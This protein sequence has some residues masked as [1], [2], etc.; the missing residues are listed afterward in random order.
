MW[1]NSETFSVLNSIKTRDWGDLLGWLGAL[2]SKG[3]NYW[4]HGLW[5]HMS[6]TNR[7]CAC[8]GGSKILS[9]LIRFF[10]E[11]NS[12][13]GWVLVGFGGLDFWD[14][15]CLK[16]LLLFQGTPPRIP[17]HQPTQINNNS[18]LVD[19]WTAGDFPTKFSQDLIGKSVTWKP[20]YIIASLFWPT[21]VEKKW[22]YIM[23]G[24]LK[25]K[26]CRFFYIYT[27]ENQG[28]RI[29]MAFFSHKSSL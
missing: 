12:A 16:G 2:V 27:S 28:N 15:P 5:T 20:W 6:Y 3:T 10:F 13:K 18:P 14:P 19:T 22:T 24:L 23:H 26:G 1:T 17:N 11:P 7:A 21:W 4:E 25:W 8:L 29:H 9:C